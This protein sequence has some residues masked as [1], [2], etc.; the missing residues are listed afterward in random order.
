[1]VINFT[2]FYPHTFESPYAAYLIPKNLKVGEK[3]YIEDLIEDYAGISWNQGDVLRLEGCE[4]IW[5][6]E[7][8]DILYEEATQE[9]F[10]G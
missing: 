3:V 1:M 4:A 8:F 7:D 2:R 5:N 10:I 6:G 9:T